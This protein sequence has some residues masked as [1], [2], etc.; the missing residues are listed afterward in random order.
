MKKFNCPKCGKELV[1]L[2]P[3]SNGKYIFCCDDC[4]LDITIEDNKL[5][6]K[7]TE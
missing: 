2:G 1:R 5:I 7:E 4:D 6:E 3:F